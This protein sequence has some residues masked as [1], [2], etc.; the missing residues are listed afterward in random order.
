MEWLILFGI[1]VGI[2]GLYYLV[3]KILDECEEWPD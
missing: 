3:D 2:V 1:I